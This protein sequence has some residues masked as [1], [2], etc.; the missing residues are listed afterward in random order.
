MGFTGTPLLVRVQDLIRLFN[1]FLADTRPGSGD[2]PAR[3]I[4]GRL[5][6]EVACYHAGHWVIGG[7][8]VGSHLCAWRP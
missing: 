5:A 3:S 7:D 6:A 2:D 8:H 1:A 4:Q